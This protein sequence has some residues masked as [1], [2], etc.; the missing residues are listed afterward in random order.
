[1][2]FVYFNEVKLTAVGYK[3]QW[4]GSPGRSPLGGG[5]GEMLPVVLAGVPW[6]PGPAQVKGPRPWKGYHVGQGLDSD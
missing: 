2:G 4:N 6:G 1:M 3:R 5:V